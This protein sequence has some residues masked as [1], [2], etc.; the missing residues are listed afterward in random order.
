[1]VWLV[2]TVAYA[3]RTLVAESRAI[4]VLMTTLAL[5]ALA[6]L[7]AASRSGSLRAAA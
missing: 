5:L 6:T 3:R 7:L 4:G 2:F 1:V